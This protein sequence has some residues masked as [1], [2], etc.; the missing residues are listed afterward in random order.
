M[1][2]AEAAAQRD[3]DLFFFDPSHTRCSCAARI[4]TLDRRP[5]RPPDQALGFIV[6]WFG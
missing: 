6:L 4:N 1:E 3:L 5:D 2:P